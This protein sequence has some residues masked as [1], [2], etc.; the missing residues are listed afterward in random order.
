MTVKN[1]VPSRF[2]VD[3]P[4]EEDTGQWWVLQ[5][6]PN[7]EWKLAK[8]LLQREISYYMPLYDRK[9]K[10]GSFGREK[11]IKAP[12]FRGYLCFALDREKQTFL[13]NTHDFVRIIEIKEQ[14]TFVK[15][16]QS[17]SKL[18][19]SGQDLLVKPGV[20]KG[21]AALIAS[22]PLKGVEG[23]VVRRAKKGRGVGAISDDTDN[24]TGSRCNR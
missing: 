13:Y 7:R 10:F 14:D 19:T 20:L 1:D 12:L 2:P 4:I 5:S 22:G 6:K 8:Y 17:V 24:W 23:V 11:V 18:T 9:V 16:L 3:R 21:R 15:E